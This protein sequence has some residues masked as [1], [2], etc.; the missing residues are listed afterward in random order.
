MRPLFCGKVTRD[1]L[2]KCIML[3]LGTV[4]YGSWGHLQAPTLVLSLLLQAACASTDHN[5]VRLLFRACN[6]LPSPSSLLC[7]LPR[8]AKAVNLS[9]RKQTLILLSLFVY[10][11]SPPRF[12][13]TNDGCGGH[14]S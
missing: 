10:V 8:V 9:R 7:Q 1:L 13:S 4:D 12:V 11:H 2:S 5:T 3:L 6:P 14:V